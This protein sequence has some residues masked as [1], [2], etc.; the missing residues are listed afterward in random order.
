[1]LDWFTGIKMQ[2][3]NENSHADARQNSILAYRTTINS[4]Q[5]KLICMQTN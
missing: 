2:D 1:M 5:N 3:A 4:M